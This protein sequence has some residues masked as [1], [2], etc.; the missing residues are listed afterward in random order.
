MTFL[1]QPLYARRLLESAKLS[2]LPVIAAH[3]E[4]RPQIA[5]N[6]L[7]TTTLDWHCS[8]SE[9]YSWHHTESIEKQAFCQ[10]VICSNFSIPRVRKILEESRFGEPEEVAS[11]GS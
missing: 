5:E 10:A 4:I 8:E 7:K 1:A 11:R 3:L 2:I 6:D 9:N